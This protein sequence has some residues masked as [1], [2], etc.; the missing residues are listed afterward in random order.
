[1][2]IGQIY[3]IGIAVNNLDEA[4]HRFSEVFDLRV[5]ER[6]VNEAQEVEWAW[7][8]T[9]RVV[10][11]VIQP[12]SRESKVSRFL[13]RRGEGL[14]LIGIEVS[15]LEVAMKELKERSVELVFE[16]PRPFPG[17]RKHN[18]IHPKSLHGVL[19]EL[20]EQAR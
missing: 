9:D 2:L 10:L 5:A 15:D 18:F 16:T 8:P 4:I 20:V 3:R 6:R 7:L 14:F 1:M 13:E 11:E 19:V 17:G 12:I